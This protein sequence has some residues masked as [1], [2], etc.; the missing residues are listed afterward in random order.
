MKQGVVVLMLLLAACTTMSDVTD[1]SPC[2][3]NYD[4]V[5]QGS[6]A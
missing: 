1:R 5:N 6:L 3:C 4:F 2:A